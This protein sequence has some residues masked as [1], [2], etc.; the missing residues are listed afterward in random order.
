MD[1]F[2][3]ALATES[4]GSFC[5]SEPASGSDAF[6]ML[7]TA[8]PTSPTS[9][10][11]PS[12]YTLNGSKCWITNAGHAKVFL[13]FAQTDP[14]LPVHL[15]Y[16]GI[17]C[18]VIPRDTPGFTVAK[19][20]K[21]LGIRASS[22]CVV[23]FDDVVV[24]RD[25][26]LGNVGEG[27][28]IAMGLLNEGRVGIGAQM[29][30]LAQGAWEAGAK[31]AFTERKQFGKYIGQFQGLGFQVAEARMEIEAA[32]ALVYNAVRTKESLDRLRA[33]GEEVGRDELN[34]FVMQAAMAKLY[35][36]KVAQKVSGDAI[37]WM[38]GMGFVRDG[39]AEKMW[40]DSKIGAIYEGVSYSRKLLVFQHWIL[41]LLLF[42]LLPYFIPQF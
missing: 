35:A 36:S 39:L 26:I 19:K 17:T 18:F 37:E 25:H 5:L 4:V 27:Y 21:K 42:F 12:S 32:R 8:R 33:A 11:D 3:P 38:G 20:E 31:Y 16:K 2:L 22:T 10:G 40:R 28:K 29:I 23:T 1:T 30:G 6:A 24:P 7:T 15:R 9:I 13:V 41:F 34:Q 14:T